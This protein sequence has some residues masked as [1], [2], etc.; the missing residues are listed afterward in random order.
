VDTT[1]LVKDMIEDGRLV[2][3]QLVRDGFD[4]A[5]AFWLKKAENGQWYFYVV[6]PCGREGRLLRR[7]SA[8]PSVD[9]PPRIGMDRSLG[10]SA[11]RAVEPYRA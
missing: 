8:P 2:I 5:T 10:G 6:S 7:L 4:L 3:E 9:S 1:A 11:N